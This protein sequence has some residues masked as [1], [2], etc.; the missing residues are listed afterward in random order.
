MLSQE[1][2][3]CTMEAL[4]HVMLS[5]NLSNV[6]VIRLNANKNLINEY[7]GEISKQSSSTFYV[8]YKVKVLKMK[9][10]HQGQFHKF[11]NVGCHG[12]VSLL[13][14]LTWNIKALR[15]TVKHF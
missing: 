12:K 2:K 15:Q 5:N 10:R 13:E 6:K 4:N 11:K 9:S 1:M 7:P 14:M 8:F 3:R